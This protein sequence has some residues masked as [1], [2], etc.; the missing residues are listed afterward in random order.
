MFSNQVQKAPQEAKKPGLLGLIL[1]SLASSGGTGDYKC[2]KCGTNLR[3]PDNL[4]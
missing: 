1:S 2:T 3:T 4:D